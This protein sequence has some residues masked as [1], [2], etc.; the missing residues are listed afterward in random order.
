[1]T[2][3]TVCR[4]FSKDTSQDF[5][6]FRQELLKCEE[7]FLHE[8]NQ[9]KEIERF[10]QDFNNYAQP[11]IDDLDSCTFTAEKKL[12]AAMI[13]PMTR[14]CSFSSSLN[15]SKKYL[16]RMES[17][18]SLVVPPKKSEAQLSDLEILELQLVSS[19]S[20]GQVFLKTVALVELKHGLFPQVKSRYF[21][22]LLHATALAYNAGKWQDHLLCCLASL[23]HWHLFI[24]EVH[25]D[26]SG[27]KHFAITKYYHH[28]HVFG[29]PYVDFYSSLVVGIS[30]LIVYS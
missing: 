10:Q 22:Q 9:S 20:S 30:H 3:S 5:K 29:Q 14:I 27:G 23:R 12:R 19:S 13:I 21:S 4:Y 15:P 7:V 2:W 1:M 28:A 25:T 18:V 6:I 11:L 16:F 17:V 24:V 26:P 8:V